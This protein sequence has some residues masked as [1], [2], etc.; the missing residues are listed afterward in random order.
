MI[1]NKFVT[2][3]LKDT[4]KAIFASAPRR[5]GWFFMARDWWSILSKR[6]GKRD[7]KELPN[8]KIINFQQTLDSRFYDF[9]FLFRVFFFAAELMQ[10][11]FLA[12]ES[13][14]SL[15][16]EEKYKKAHK[17]L[18]VSLCAGGFISEMRNN[19]SNSD[20]RAA[21]WHSA[22]DNWRAEGGDWGEGKV[23][24]VIVCIQ[25]EFCTM[26]C[27]CVSW[28]LECYL[29]WNWRLRGFLND[30]TT[31]ED[32]ERQLRCETRRWKVSWIAASQ[33]RGGS[34]DWIFA[35]VC[36]W[37]INIWN[38]DGRFEFKDVKVVQISL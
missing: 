7:L 20:N 28:M 30:E 34:F 19:I 27:H 12:H 23:K 15:G 37:V 18:F 1:I 33:R 4:S 11:A 13:I 9:F 6:K 14:S 16:G 21:T 3:F 38:W 22:A 2:I 31:W 32:F 24:E 25:K 17:K 26:S 36:F 35:A 10:A 8:K 5:A 29:E